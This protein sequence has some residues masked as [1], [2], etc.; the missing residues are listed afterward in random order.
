L[1]NIPCPSSSLL[2]RARELGQSCVNE[3]A[4]AK[5]PVPFHRVDLDKF[6]APDPSHLWS[7]NDIE[8]LCSKI[9]DDLYLATKS[10]KRSTQMKYHTRSE[11]AYERWKFVLQS[12][13]AKQIW[14]S[15]DW[16]GSFDTAYDQSDKPTDAEFCGYYHELL[17]QTDE[18][19][20]DLASFTPASGIYVPVLDDPISPIEVDN[21]VK[22]LKQNKAAGVDGVPPGILK[23]INAEWILLLTFVFNRI[24][25][26]YYP[27]CWSFA[28]VF[29]IFKKGNRLSPENYRGIS[30]LNALAKL[31]DLILC[32][33]FT[34]WYR[35]REEEA[36]AQK[37]KGC[38][39]IVDPSVN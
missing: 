20:E 5:R 14:Q 13:D 17:S 18:N 7:I 1:G 12:G 36:G 4:F 38:A 28:K 22:C 34:L 2:Q 10:A 9:S 35:P 8:T 16:H 39:N 3:A 25:L 29:S 6:S 21:A 32:K 23:V 33:R 27:E 15:I 26:N 30:I 31:Y 37:G 24:F 11:N 19:F